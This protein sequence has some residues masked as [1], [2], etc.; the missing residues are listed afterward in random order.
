M[1]RSP[2][3]WISRLALIGLLGLAVSPHAAA[4]WPL[5]FELAPW[6]LVFW[7]WTPPSAIPTSDLEEQPLAE[8]GGIDPNGQSAPA[9]PQLP[10][11]RAQTDP[12]EDQ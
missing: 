4:E 12:P 10:V 7:S 9:P 5:R 2:S 3:R 1:N 11:T 6:W 8:G